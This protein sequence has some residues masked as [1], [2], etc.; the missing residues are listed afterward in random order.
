MSDK[1]NLSDYVDVPARI[2]EFRAKYPAG[3]LQPADLSTPYRVETIG[4]KTFVVV[5]AAA[6][7]TPDD[8]RP[9]VGMAYEL[10]PGRTSFTKD[11]ELQNAETS[12]W[13]RAIVAVLAADTKR[14]VASQEEVRNRRADQEWESNPTWDAAEQEMLV[15]GWTAEL[16]GAPTADAV[17]E[18]G[19]RVLLQ[20]NRKELSPNSFEG[21][22]KVAAGRLAEIAKEAQ[23]DEPN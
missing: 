20:M 18:V 5:V 12:A 11:S 14:S 7:R 21:L 4:D 8:I 13:G 2:A 17:K 3:C 19:R 10:F 23:T 22:Q 15:A 1:V 16:Q 9:G 6:Y